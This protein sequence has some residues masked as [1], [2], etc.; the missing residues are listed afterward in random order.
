MAHTSEI[1]IDELHTLKAKIKETQG[2]LFGEVLSNPIV[3]R[4]YD[5]LGEISKGIDALMR[6]VIAQSPPSYS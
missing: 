6:V 4:W 5:N 2:L 1:L 3:S